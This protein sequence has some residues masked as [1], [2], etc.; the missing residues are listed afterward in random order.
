MRCR[1]RSGLGVDPSV[2]HS[3]GAEA[4]GLALFPIVFKCNLCTSES[5]VG[6][7]QKWRHRSD[8]ASDSASW[9]GRCESESGVGV[10]RAARAPPRRRL[11]SG[12]AA[13][14]RKRRLHVLP[15]PSK[16]RHCFYKNDA[17]ILGCRQHS[18]PK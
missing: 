3:D 15:L 8:R 4:F 5:R 18:R 17:R 9:S 12:I 16:I 1:M 2:N 11:P 13:I 10:V 14:D 6:V 7:V